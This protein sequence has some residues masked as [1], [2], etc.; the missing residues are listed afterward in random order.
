MTIPPALFPEVTAV[1]LCRP[2]EALLCGSLGCR[3]GLVIQAGSAARG[4]GVDPTGRLVGLAQ[5][6]GSATWL[7]DR[8][9]AE[10]NSSPRL[11]AAARKRFP[12]GVPEDS[13]RVAFCQDVLRLASFPGPDPV[14]RALVLKAARALTDL[15]RYLVPRLHLLQNHRSTWSGVAFEPTLLEAFSAEVNRHLPKLRWEEPRFS[16]EFGC[17]LLA[18]AAL[19]ERLRRGLTPEGVN[20]IGKDQWRHVFRIRKPLPELK[21]D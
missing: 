17:A 10:Q 7:A 9:L 5:D 14:C 21:P 15:T 3:A 20:T 6:T 19:D 1:W 4:L 12:E 13:R 2:Q 8:G 16:A 18:Q 11:Q